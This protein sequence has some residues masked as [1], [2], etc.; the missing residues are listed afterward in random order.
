MQLFEYL[1]LPA[2]RRGQKAK[3]L[4]TPAE[5][6]AHELT[7]LMNDL[8]SEGWEYWRSECLPSEERKGLMSSTVIENHLLIFRRP[9]AEALAES[10]I[11]QAAAPEA[12]PRSKWHGV[13]APRGD[14]TVYDSRKEPQL[15]P[16]KPGAGG[17]A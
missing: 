5:R 7:T 14:R 11:G 8:S 17:E 9:K 15:T 13:E 2:P 1:A 16:R 6:Y 10:L 4:K 12:D 3:G